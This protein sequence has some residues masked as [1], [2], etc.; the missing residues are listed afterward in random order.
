MRSPVVIH[1]Y[2]LQGW[3]AVILLVG[4]T[5]MDAGI[6]KLL[7]DG[8]GAKVNM[9]RQVVVSTFRAGQAGSAGVEAAMPLV[10]GTA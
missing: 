3:T 4:G 5:V 2:L 1:V 10:N 8:G 6:G 9:L 7:Q